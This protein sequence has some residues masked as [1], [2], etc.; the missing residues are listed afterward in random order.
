MIFFNHRCVLCPPPQRGERNHERSHR[1]PARRKKKSCPRV[2]T[3]CQRYVCMLPRCSFLDLIQGCKPI[4]LSL[5]LIKKLQT[6]AK[7]SKVFFSSFFCNIKSSNKTRLLA[8]CGKHW[9]QRKSKTL[10]IYHNICHEFDV[11]LS[12]QDEGKGC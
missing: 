2:L 11:T 3:R 6:L 9:K 5:N 7:V 10:F 4:R 8:C 1:N 12:A